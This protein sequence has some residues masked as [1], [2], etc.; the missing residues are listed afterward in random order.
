VGR[1][2]GAGGDGV[3]W[4]GRV[5]DHRNKTK[6]GGTNRGEGRVSAQQYR[7]CRMVADTEGRAAPGTGEGRIPAGRKEEPRR[8]IGRGERPQK[9]IRG[10]DTRFGVVRLEQ[11]G[12]VGTEK[13]RICLPKM[14]ETGRR[15]REATNILSSST[16]V[17]VARGI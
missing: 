13:A 17:R 3:M 10:L 1:R 7:V 9:E 11:S 15:R 14:R 12:R 2:W 8:W 6:L 5:L 16:L 4:G